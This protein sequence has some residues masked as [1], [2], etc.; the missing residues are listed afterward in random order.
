M[1]W[2]VE[3]QLKNGLIK[4]RFFCEDLTELHKQ[5]AEKYPTGKIVSIVGW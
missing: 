2:K 4:D 5:I 3:I 1:T